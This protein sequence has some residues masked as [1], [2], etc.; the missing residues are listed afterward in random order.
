MAEQWWAG[1]HGKDTP[2]WQ[3]VGRSPHEMIIEKESQSQEL[4]GGLVQGERWTDLLPN[5]LVI[6]EKKKQVSTCF[7]SPGN[8][9]PW[10]PVKD[11]LNYSQ[12]QV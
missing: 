2:G 5:V 7:L 1:G 11:T 12:S 9:Q 8:E 10:S 6:S 4:Q 3:E